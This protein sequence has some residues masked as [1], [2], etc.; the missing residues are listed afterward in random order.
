MKEQC[1][2]IILAAGSSSRLGTPK[3]LLHYK[4]NTLI[5]HSI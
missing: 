5:Q 3:Q 1:D 4:H 2:I